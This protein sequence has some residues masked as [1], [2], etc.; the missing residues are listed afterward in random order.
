MTSD[1]IFDETITTILYQ[2]GRHDVAEKCGEIILK[3]RMLSIAYVDETL[4]RDAWQLF[5]DRTEALELHRLHIIHID[6]EDWRSDCFGVRRKLR[7]SGLHNQTLIEAASF[8]LSYEVDW[9]LMKLEIDALRRE[10]LDIFGSSATVWRM[11][12]HISIGAEF[13]NKTG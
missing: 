3:S 12:T 6:G 1:Y 8:Q 10:L 13:L 7:E 9:K 5:K 11:A 4:L 2:T